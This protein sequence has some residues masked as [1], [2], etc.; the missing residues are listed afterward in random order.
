MDVVD[1]RDRRIVQPDDHVAWLEASRLGGAARRHLDDA[2]PGR[3]AQ[4]VLPRDGGSSGA[5]SAGRALGTRQPPGAGHPVPSRQA[6]GYSSGN[7]ASVAERSS[8]WF[9][10]STP[11][12]TVVPIAARL[13]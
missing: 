5:T 7:G 11:I 10:R 8:R 13:R 4:T 2:D 6:G 9:R 12:R 3:R 1:I